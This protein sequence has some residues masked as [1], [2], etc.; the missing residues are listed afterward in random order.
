[1]PMIVH[2]DSY[3]EY[4]RETALR[5]RQVHDL[6]LRG[7][8]QEKITRLICE[9]IIK[10]VALTADDDLVDIGCGDGTLLRLAIE[11]GVHRAVGFQATDEEAFVLRAMG[12]NVKQGLSH[13]L[14]LPAA[15]ASI[16]V[17]NNVL[18]I[19]PAADIPNTLQ[20]ISRVAKSGARIY[21]GE[22]PSIAGPAPE[23][24]FASER[25]TLLY[26]YHRYGL[27][28]SFGM[29]RRM[30][31]CKL[32]GEALTIYDCAS[33]S[34]YAEP[35]QF[36]PMVETAGLSLLRYWPHEYW[37]TRNNYLFQKSSRT[38]QIEAA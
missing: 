25:Q 26:L 3:V 9:R 36:I 14:P 16:I 17:C 30:A 23:P 11:R 22:I 10:E 15:S 24:R 1:M 32:L 29:L 38:D 34:F 21:L 27:R 18:L 31:R 7:R 35:D 5:L 33:I 19:V 37:P 20:E 12:L 28:T 6:A 2:S 13:C 8:G 4:C